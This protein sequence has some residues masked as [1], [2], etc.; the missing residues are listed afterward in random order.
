[1]ALTKELVQKIADQIQ[2]E[3]F[4]LAKKWEVVERNYFGGYMF[5]PAPL[6][7]V[8]DKK[9]YFDIEFKNG[10]L[11]IRTSFKGDVLPA[12]IKIEKL[13]NEESGVS[14]YFTLQ[15]NPGFM[16]HVDIF[17]E[18]PAKTNGKK[19]EKLLP[20]LKEFE[21]KGYTFT[22]NLHG[23]L[24][25]AKDGVI[26]RVNYSGGE[27]LYIEKYPNYGEKEIIEAKRPEDLLSV[28]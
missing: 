3:Y 20:A 13:F 21:K 24:N 1:M 27:V 16:S 28:V 6:Y 4:N 26:Y 19:T 9:R 15:L 8:N 11:Y 12:L 17:H 5:G 10:F 14:D 18:L 23:I 2:K 7:P 25:I 22:I